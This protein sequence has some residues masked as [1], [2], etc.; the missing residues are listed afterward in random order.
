MVTYYIL[1]FRALWTERK[2]P[3]SNTM[4][5]YNIII[6]RQNSYIRSGS[7]YTYFPK[8]SNEKFFSSPG[9]GLNRWRI[10][11]DFHPTQTLLPS[12]EISAHL[13]FSPRPPPAL[14]L[15]F[16][17]RA[18]SR[19]ILVIRLAILLS[20]VSCRLYKMCLAGRFFLRVGHRGSRPGW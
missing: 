6:L 4:Q 13:R 20:L 1:F 15:H 8:N 7:V 11:P 16:L 17:G 10:I 9:I 3:F 12:V 18:R 14:K 2:H 5:Y 19:L